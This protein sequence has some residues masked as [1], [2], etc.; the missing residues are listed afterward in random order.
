[1]T[2]TKKEQQFIKN[3]TMG[4]LKS[5]VRDWR[6]F[7]EIDED[8]HAI[9]LYTNGTAL[10]YPDDVEEIKLTNIANVNIMSSCDCRDFYYDDIATPDVIE[11]QELTDAYYLEEYGYR[12]TDFIKNQLIVDDMEDYY[13]GAF[14]ACLPELHRKKA[15]NGWV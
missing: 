14:V 15:L 7:K 2:I 10:R 4:M 1:M 6:L 11:S 9:I 5:L 8:S 13:T 12:F 3:I